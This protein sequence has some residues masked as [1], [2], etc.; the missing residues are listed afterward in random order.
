MRGIFTMAVL[1]SLIC[2]AAFAAERYNYRSSKAYR[3][4]KPAEQRMLDQVH[5]D[6]VL[7]WGPLDM[8]AEANG[9]QVPK[10]LSDVV[11]LYL[12]ELP[13][14]PFAT[15]ATARQEKLGPYSQ[16]CDGFGHRYR[17]GAGNA[18]VVSSVGL[19]G[20]PYL[21]QRGNVDLYVAKGTWISG[22]QL[23]PLN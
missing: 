22:N 17:T 3:A 23:Q 1:A 12:K 7:L 16:S 5:R 2:N 14:D 15:K 19:P 4:L 13:R 11:P 18:F 8:Y 9:G 10:K 21:A 6:F 20:F